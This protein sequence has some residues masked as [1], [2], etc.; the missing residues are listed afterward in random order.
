MRG[1]FA[2]QRAQVACSVASSGSPQHPQP[3]SPRNWTTF[4]HSA[5]K[6]CTSGTIVPK[7]AQ[8]GGAGANAYAYDGA[9]PVHCFLSCDAGHRTSRT[10]PELFDMT[11]R[12]LRRD[13]A[14][15]I[16]PELFLLDRAFSDCLERVALMNR[17]FERALLIGCP[18]PNWPD[19]LRPFAEA[20]EC[21]DPG[22]LFAESAS[23]ASIVEDGWD[24]PAQAYD[25]VATVGT[26]D[27]V[28]NLPLA[29][30]LIRHAMRAD[31]LLIG[32]VSGGDTLPRLRAAMRAA[33]STAGNAVP[34]VHPRI[35]ASALS[36]MLVD[37]GFLRPVVD[38]ERVQVA[39]RSLHRLVSDLRAMGAT[40]VLTADAPPLTRL[41]REAASR[42]FAEGAENGRTV[43]TFELIHFA[44]W[45]P[46]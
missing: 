33:D 26:L 29:L 35:E 31:S 24:A 36:P 34:H 5:Q 42:A 20:I 2:R 46:A 45:T 17:R 25:L 9:K 15:R 40:N 12:A 38:V 27:T 23:G 43:E 21:R 10:V 16:G 32:A 1:G 44:V 13:R 19:R 39:Y 22:P 3:D 18:N 4:Q 7:S 14:A 11:L 28:N 41:Q 6:L 30:R 37:A 8:R